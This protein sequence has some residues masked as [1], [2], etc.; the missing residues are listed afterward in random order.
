VIIG[1]IPETAAQ[2][3]ALLF[4]E[5]SKAA[6]FECSSAFDDERRHPVSADDL[7]EAVKSAWLKTLGLLSQTLRLPAAAQAV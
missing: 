3:Y 2:H 1:F 5:C 7:I 4:V 6:R